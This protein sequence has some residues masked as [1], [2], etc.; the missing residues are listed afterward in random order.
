[1]APR[2]DSSDS[3]ATRKPH[4]KYRGQV[5]GNRDAVA[6]CNA[7]QQHRAGQ[8]RQHKAQAA[9]PAGLLD[10]HA[11]Q[12]CSAH[13]QSIE[14]RML[15]GGPATTALSDW[16]VTMAPTR[17]TM[18]DHEEEHAGTGAGIEHP[19]TLRAARKASAVQTSYGP[20]LLLD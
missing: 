3:T 9:N 13:A 15:A 11:A 10:H 18:T 2:P 5:E 19:V 4:A 14:H 1:M 12:G 7:E 17:Q 16:L 8:C 20:K 6:G